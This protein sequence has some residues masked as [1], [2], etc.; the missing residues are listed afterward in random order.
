MFRSLLLAASWV[1][2]ALAAFRLLCMHDILTIPLL[3][4]RQNQS[5][6]NASPG[7]VLSLYSTRRS[8]VAANIY[9]CLRSRASRRLLCPVRVGSDAGL[10]RRL[11]PIPTVSSTSNTETQ[12]G[13]P[14]GGKCIFIIQ[15]TISGYVSSICQG[16]Y[17]KKSLESRH[18]VTCVNVECS[19]FSVIRRTWQHSDFKIRRH[20]RLSSQSKSSWK[21]HI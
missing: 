6:L 10:V 7:F 21:P 11:T 14:I 19:S 13:T 20:C 3:L 15:T 4:P 12:Q 18:R 2:H 1:V 9:Q 5:P 16:S 17:K 8:D